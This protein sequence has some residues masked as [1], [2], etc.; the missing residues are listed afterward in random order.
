MCKTI[1]FFTEY[2][3][4]NTYIAVSIFKS[5]FLSR[6]S[7]QCFKILTYNRGGSVREHL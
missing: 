3:L 1:I 5:V 7:I 2:M 4:Q 6:F